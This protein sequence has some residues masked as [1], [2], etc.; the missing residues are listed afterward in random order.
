MADDSKQTN[1]SSPPLPQEAYFIM[2]ILKENGVTSYEPQVVNQLLEF[3]Y[4]YMTE[5]LNDAQDYAHHSGRTNIAIE[6]IKLSVLRKSEQYSTTVL[7]RDTLMEVSREKNSS[8]LPMLK[9]YSGTRLPPDR[10]CL[11]S[12]NYRLSNDSITPRV[13]SQPSASFVDPLSAIPT[14][15]K[16]DFVN[17]QMIMPAAGIK[18]KWKDEEDYDR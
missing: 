6:D 7:S 4:S 18:R 14:N 8:N 5:R 1:G 15:T 16:K 13:R 2:D 9:T 17:P 3:I 10:Y 12:L 11:S